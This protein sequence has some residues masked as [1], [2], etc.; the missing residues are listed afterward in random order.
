M[1]ALSGW[2]ATRALEDVERDVDRFA[3]AKVLLAGRVV[4]E[5]LAVDVLSDE[6]PVA[7]LGLVGPDRP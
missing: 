6:V 5:R 3:V 1:R 4:V 2:M 7:L